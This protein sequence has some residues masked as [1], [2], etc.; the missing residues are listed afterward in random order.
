MIIISCKYKFARILDK[1]KAFWFYDSLP[2]ALTPFTL[3]NSVKK[4]PALLL[5]IFHATAPRGCLNDTFLPALNLEVKQLCSP[6]RTETYF[7]YVRVRIS[8]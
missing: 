6:F 7:L 5:A 8:A 3:S 4:P 2:I 1:P